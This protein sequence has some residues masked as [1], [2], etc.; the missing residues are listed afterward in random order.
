[1]RRCEVEMVLAMQSKSERK[2]YFALVAKARGQ[3][4]AERLR[5]EA[6]AAW[7]AAQDSLSQGGVDAPPGD[8]HQRLDDE[9]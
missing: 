2:G 5:N 7:K 1:M 4:A 6:I 8:F 3:Q 9:R